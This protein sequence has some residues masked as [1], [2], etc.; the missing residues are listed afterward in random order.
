MLINVREFFRTVKLACRF[1]KK[2]LQLYV[3][4]MVKYANTWELTDIAVMDIFSKRRANSALPVSDRALAK[5]IR[6]S[7]PRIADLFHHRHGSPSLR[8][9]IAL[10][11][12]FDLNP[13]GTID[14]ALRMVSEKESASKGE[15]E[16]A[17]R[18]N[19]IDMSRL[20]VEERADLA[21]ERFTKDQLTAAANKDPNKEREME[22]DAH[23][24]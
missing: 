5:A 4:G 10:C 16:F 11:S 24:F 2:L 17:E 6:V 3:Y 22:G 13:A 14:Q 15:P 23:D 12:V 8:E 9:F 18:G 21:V 1:V 19:A 7:P 20:S